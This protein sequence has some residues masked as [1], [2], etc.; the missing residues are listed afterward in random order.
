MIAIEEKEIRGNLSA[1]TSN[2][3]KQVFSLQD[4]K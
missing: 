1:R 3:L 4:Q 2:L